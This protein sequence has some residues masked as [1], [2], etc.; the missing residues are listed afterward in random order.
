[1]CDRCLNRTP[2]QACVLGQLGVAQ[3][4]AAVACCRG[5]GQ[6]NQ[7]GGRPPVVSDKIGQQR[8]DNIPVDRNP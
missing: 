2:R 1:M 6:V 8:I 5:Y 7:E 3:G 4:R